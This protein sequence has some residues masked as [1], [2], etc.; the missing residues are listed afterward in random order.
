MTVLNTNHYDAMKQPLFF[1][2]EP[3][4][5]RFDEAKYDIFSKLLE[6]HKGFFWQ[7]AEID[8]SDLRKDLTS[9]T[10]AE[11]HI[12]TA[13]LKYQS[14]LDSVQGRAPVMAFLPICS[15][16]QLE[17]F[18][19]YWSATES[20]IHAESYTHIIRSAYDNPSAIFDS[21]KLDNAI[22]KRAESITKYYDDLIVHNHVYSLLGF[23]IHEVKGVVYD[24]TER[25]MKKRLY[26]ALVSTNALEAVRFYVSFG[27]TFAFV[28]RR[29]AE[30]AGKI[31]RLI[32][33]DEALHYTATQ[34][35]INILAKGDDDPIAA[36][37]IKECKQE[38]IE[39]YQTVVKQEEEWA[40]YLFKEGSMIGLNAAILRDYVRYIGQ[41][42][43]SHI[44]LDLGYG[45]V[46]NPIP[47]I[48][49]HLSSDNVQVA[50]QESEISS[51]LS[52]SIDASDTADLEDFSDFEL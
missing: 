41:E 40:E 12:F 17:A 48:N 10:P 32:A 35:M 49:H 50:P 6:R 2:E 28:E 15:N 18:I 25:A 39:I 5:V 34:H 51:Y 42:R 37:V 38:A 4:I 43:A 45:R 21:I 29:K 26:L 3:D 19:E 33:R 20:G 30:S 16:A 27:C 23:G 36:E 24:C 46:S 52:N 11:H 7:S 22:M 44:G 47:W 8:V 14:L 1:G 13:N 9:M 31:V